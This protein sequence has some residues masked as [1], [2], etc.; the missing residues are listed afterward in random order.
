MTND[1]TQMT[2]KSF[3]DKALNYLDF[4]YSFGF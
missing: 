2:N 3:N 4:N 1:K